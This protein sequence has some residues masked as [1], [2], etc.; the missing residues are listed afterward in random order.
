MPRNIRALHIRVI[1]APAATHITSKPTS[2]YTT[3]QRLLATLE[4][5]VELSG[6]RKPHSRSDLIILGRFLE[7]VY[8]ALYA[9]SVK[10]GFNFNHPV[11]QR[12]SLKKLWER[13]IRCNRQVNAFVDV[14]IKSASY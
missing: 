1:D 7:N 4:K 13:W 5:L 10:L 12:H 14:F 2:K 6:K 11:Y 8:D 3:L 9:E